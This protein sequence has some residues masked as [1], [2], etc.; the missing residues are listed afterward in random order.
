MHRPNK[1]RSLTQ[2]MATAAAVAFFCLQTTPAQQPP[3]PPAQQEGD[4]PV[5]RSDSRLVVLHATVVDKKG[6][7]VTNLPRDAFK[8]YENGVQQPLKAFKRED[9]PVSLGLVIDNSGSMRNK[10]TKVESSALKLV[11]L[12]NRQDEVFIVNFNDEAFLD[13][14]FTNKVPDMEKA[15]ARIDSRGGTAM[16]DSLRMSIDY[17]TEEAKLDKKVLLVITDGDDNNSS[18]TLENVVKA[19]QRKEIMVYAIGLL[20]EEERRSAKRA[21]RALEAITEATGGQA[22]FPKELEDVDA[23]AEQVANDIRNQYVL[24]YVPTNQALDGSFRQIRVTVDGPNRPQVRT[25]S[26]YYATPDGPQR[27]AALTKSGSD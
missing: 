14:P 10:R 19:A 18:G 1:L 9:V 21:K 13:Q 25:R 26:G 17:V 2:Y 8:V 5:F 12:S 6:N 27:G 7:L 22:Y 20:S 23:I 24:E 15:L 11:K 3:K 4:V 16:R